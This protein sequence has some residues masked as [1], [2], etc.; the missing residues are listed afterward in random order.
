M[1]KVLLTYALHMSNAIESTHLLAHVVCLAHSTCALHI[2][3][4]VVTLP[5]YLHASRQLQQYIQGGKE[6][7]NRRRKE[8]GR[9]HCI[10]GG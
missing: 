1:S 8:K 6:T 7:E 3:E 2:I 4:A 9:A 10:R 5:L